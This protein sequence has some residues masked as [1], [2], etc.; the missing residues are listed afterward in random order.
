PGTAGSWRRRRGNHPCARPYRAGTGSPAPPTG[1]GRVA[2]QY[3][4]VRTATTTARSTSPLTTM[5]MRVPSLGPSSSDTVTV[6]ASV[7]VVASGPSVPSPG[8]SRLVEVVIDSV[9]VVISTSSTLVVVGCDGA[10]VDGGAVGGGAVD[11]VVGAVVV[12]VVSTD[13]GG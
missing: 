2:T 1:S 3:R 5:A 9:V 11:V 10:R 7:V 8:T 6:A 12:V 13:D 4:Q